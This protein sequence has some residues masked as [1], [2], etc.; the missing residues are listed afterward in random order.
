[1]EDYQLSPLNAD[2][3]PFTPD[4]VVRTLSAPFPASTVVA[5]LPPTSA[6]VNLDI[7]G[8]FVQTVRMMLSFESLILRWVFCWLRERT[9]QRSQQV[10]LQCWVVWDDMPDPFVFSSFLLR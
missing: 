7:Q 3:L 8:G 9:L 6:S 2:A 4:L 10:H 1:M 5:V